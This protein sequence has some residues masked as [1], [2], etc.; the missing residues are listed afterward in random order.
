MKT[1]TAEATGARQGDLPSVKVC[2]RLF[3][4]D[5]HAHKYIYIYININVCIYIY[6]YIYILC[7]HV[8]NVM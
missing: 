8:C 6:M 7:M 2:R 4:F 1:E 3:M 5:T